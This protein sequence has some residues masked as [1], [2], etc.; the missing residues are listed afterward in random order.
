MHLV[1]YGDDNSGSVTIN[2]DG[3]RVRLKKKPDGTWYAVEGEATLESV[4]RSVFA[5]LGPTMA[6]LAGKPDPS[7]PGNS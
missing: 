7:K 3:A 6:L 1:L 4:H 2:A 5:A